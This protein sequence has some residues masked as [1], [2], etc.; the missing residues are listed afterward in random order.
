MLQFLKPIRVA[1]DKKASPKS[2]TLA[3]MS[4]VAFCCETVYLLSGPSFTA[5]DM[6][7]DTADLVSPPE[8]RK[9]KAF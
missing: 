3:N 9:A 4:A 5:I 2:L 8:A 1:W 6:A 7:T